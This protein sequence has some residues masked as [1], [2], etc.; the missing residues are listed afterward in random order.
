VNV[1]GC[2]VAF[3]DDLRQPGDYYRCQ[4]RERG[5]LVES[6]WFVMPNAPRRDNPTDR[7]FGYIGGITFPPW[8]ERECPDGSLEVRASI[9]V[10][11]HATLDEDG[12]RVE[13]PG[14]HG[15]LDEGHVWREV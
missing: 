3:M 5:E 9:A 6:M 10:S 8:T 12:Q 14:W 13:V 11:P 4:V 1:I 2:R 7:H 15:F